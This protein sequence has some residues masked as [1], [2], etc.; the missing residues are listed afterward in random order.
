MDV[1]DWFVDIGESGG[2]VGDNVDGAVVIAVDG[3]SLTTEGDTMVLEAGVFN[4]RGCAVVF[5]KKG[6]T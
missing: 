3:V 6:W 1:P 2:I 4:G 5:V